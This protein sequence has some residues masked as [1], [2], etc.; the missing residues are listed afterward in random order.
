MA[1]IPII[2]GFAISHSKKGLEDQNSV[3]KYIQRPSATDT[4]EV[5]A[6]GLNAKATKNEKEQERK[7]K[8][9]KIAAANDAATKIFGMKKVPV[10]N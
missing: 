5:S 9:D 4:D 7:K 10:L 6:R 2:K 3:N 1:R 8:E